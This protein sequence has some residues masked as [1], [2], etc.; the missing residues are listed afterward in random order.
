MNQNEMLKEITGKGD[1]VARKRIT[2][3]KRLRHLNETIDTLKAHQDARQE[4]T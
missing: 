1:P 3:W 4:E 2:L